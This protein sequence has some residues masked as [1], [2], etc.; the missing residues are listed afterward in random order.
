M[1][2]S[3]AFS[4][5]YLSELVIQSAMQAA[6]TEQRM[7]RIFMS[8]YDSCADWI[9]SN[10]EFNTDWES[11]PRRRAMNLPLRNS[12]SSLLNVV[13]LVNSV[14]EFELKIHILFSHY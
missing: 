14:I 8:H 9:Y 13:I 10:Y 3:S 6:E 4:K 11:L 2:D 7:L 12:C 1:R 5:H